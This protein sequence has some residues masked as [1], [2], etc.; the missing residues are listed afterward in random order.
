MKA[1]LF[2]AMLVIV[3]AGGIG[4]ASNATAVD[5]ADEISAPVERTAL[6]QIEVLDLT[7]AEHGPKLDRY[8]RQLADGA[9]TER[10]FRGYLLDLEA[11]TKMD[12]LKHQV[13]CN[14]QHAWRSDASSFTRK[15]PIAA[16]VTTSLAYVQTGYAY[17]LRC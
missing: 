12:A 13:A 9:I 17:P 1:Y 10:E 4:L 14:H 16:A 8:L 2:A 3:T 11:L 5:D 6:V 7:I 15:E